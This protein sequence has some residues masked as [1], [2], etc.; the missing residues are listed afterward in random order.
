MFAE[1]RF[2]LQPS[3]AIIG[4]SD[5]NLF[6]TPQVSAGDRILR[7]RPA[8]EVLFASPRLSASGD[9]E[10]DNDRYATHSG[11]SNRRARQRATAA[12]QYQISP[13]LQV[14]FDGGF[15][16]TD[17]PAEFN[18]TTGLGSLRRR[19]QQLT[20]RPSGRLR[21][22]P[23]LSAHAALLSTDEKV[24]GGSRM[25]SQVFAA[26]MD[27]RMTPRDTLALDFEQAHYDFRLAPTATQTNSSV[28]RSTWSH[29][30]DTRTHFALS[31]GPRITAGQI[32]P[33]LAASL[34]HRWLS[35]SI[36]MSVSQTETTA[37]GIDRPV[38][39]R[40]IDVRFGWEPT[41]SF[42]AYVAPAI[43]RTARQGLQATVYH[44]GIGA[45]YAL[46][47]LVGFD[48]AYTFDSERG[49]IDPVHAVGAFSRS[50][51]TAGFTTRW[52]APDTINP[53][54]R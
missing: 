26:G 33:E 31:A 43:F 29:D 49:A 12:T 8:L 11:L 54:T 35:S 23:L 53:G 46:T 45:R 16:D 7:I 13:R 10:F 1:N 50:T 15:T 19:A 32:K 28:V 42:S 25:R 37:I 34:S 38:Q 24:V 22:S 2:A 9:Y 5:D 41:R 14:G 20:F 48:A 18:I 44:A 21:I 47:P 6:F 4:V 17:T 30:I 36:T 27:R 39:A 3:V 52:S 51:F 40:A